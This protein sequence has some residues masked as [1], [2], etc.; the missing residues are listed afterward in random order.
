MTPSPLPPLPTARRQE[1]KALAHA[2]A[3]V[4]IIGDA[5]LTDGVLREI[6]RNLAAHQLIKVRVAGEDRQQR[7]AVCSQIAEQSHAYPVQQIGKLLVLFRPDPAK[8]APGVSAAPAPAA[9]RKRGKSVP[10]SKPAR[11]MPAP[12]PSRSAAGKGSA[13][14]PRT[15]R[16]RKAGQRSAKK[17]FQDS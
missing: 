1:L 17:P 7:S 9:A 12:R 4:V 16:V 14:P 6:E 3:P 13:H 5:G 15:A 10:K 2:L 11:G 8:A